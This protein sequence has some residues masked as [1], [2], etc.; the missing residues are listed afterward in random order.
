MTKKKIFSVIAILTL[1]L[2]VTGCSSTSDDDLTTSGDDNFMLS[3]AD[4]PVNN[5]KEVNVTLKEV[6]VIREKNGEE[7]KETITDFNGGEKTFD[8]LNLRFNVVQ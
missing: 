2:V 7:I 8:L 5:I 1:V 4:A 6:K 3:L